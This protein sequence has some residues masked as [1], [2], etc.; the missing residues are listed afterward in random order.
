[1]NPQ[2]FEIHHT[3]EASAASIEPT[4]TTGTSPPPVYRDDYGRIVHT[5]ER[6]ALAPEHRDWRNAMIELRQWPDHQPLADRGWAAVGRLVDRIRAA[7]QEGR[8]A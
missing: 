5:P 8:T 2:Q 3:I 4:R 1:M 6:L 7:R